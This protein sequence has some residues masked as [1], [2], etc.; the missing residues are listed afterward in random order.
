MDYPITLKPCDHCGRATL[1]NCLYCSRQCA[2]A[3]K[4]KTE[5]THDSR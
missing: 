4:T 3:A 1:E 5:A 2:D